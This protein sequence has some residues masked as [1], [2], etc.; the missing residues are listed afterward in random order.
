MIKQ[1]VVVYLASGR[2]ARIPITATGLQSV[3]RLL[4]HQIVLRHI[5]LANIVKLIMKL[6]TLFAVVRATDIFAITLPENMHGRKYQIATV[7]L[8][9]RPVA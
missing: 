2:V 5:I 9:R 3:V 7:R 8:L 6:E 4:P 1:P